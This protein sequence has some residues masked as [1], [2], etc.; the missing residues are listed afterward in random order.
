M[1]AMTFENHMNNQQD[2]DSSNRDFD[3]LADAIHHVMKRRWRAD[4]DLNHTSDRGGFDGKRN[5]P[6]PFH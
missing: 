1:P 4:G 2:L 5:E 6:D 3:S